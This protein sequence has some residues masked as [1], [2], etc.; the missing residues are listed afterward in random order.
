MKQGFTAFKMKVGKNI[1]DDKRRAKII[2]ETIGKNGI[3]M[4]DAN[5]I[6][7]VSTAIKWMKELKEYNI[8]WIEEPTSPDDIIGHL[9]ISKELNPLGILVATGEHCSNQVLFRQFLELNALQIVQP[10]TCRLCSIPEIIMVLLLSKIYHKPVCMH[11]GGVGLNEMARHFAMIDYILISKN[12][13]DRFW[14]YAQHL[15]QHFQEETDHINAKY[16]P[17]LQ[18]GYVRIKLS[19][20]QQYQFPNG[21]FWKQRLKQNNSKL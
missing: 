11:A 7:N 18:S 8:Y 14:E 15:K 6:W 12:K 2:R 10:D 4:T 21:N 17:P 13:K 5:Q 20:I 9:I 1:E 19:S 16:F 3:I